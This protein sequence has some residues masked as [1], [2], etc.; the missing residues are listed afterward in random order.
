MR[1]IAIGDSITS[2]QYLPSEQAWPAILAELTGHEVL[3]AGVANETT[4]QGL[5]R[6]PRHVQERSPDV[7][8]IQ[9]GLNDCNRW[10]TDNGLPRVSL[11]A[12]RENLIEMVERVRACG[13]APMIADITPTQKSAQHQRDRNE[14]RR[15]AAFVAV[16]QGARFIY[17]N[18]YVR[19]LLDAVHL[20]PEGHRIF[21]EG[22]ARCLQSQLVSAS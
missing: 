18:L 22:A 11:G 2:G 5:E 8:I 1:I 3:N 12:Y 10:K 16:D 15:A 4:R 20:T 19:H 6:F 17:A 14:Y 7:V 13:A 9:F 21:A